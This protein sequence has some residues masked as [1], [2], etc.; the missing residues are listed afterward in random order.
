MVCNARKTNKQTTGE[1]G[2]IG[3]IQNDTNEEEK[4]EKKKRIRDPG[5][6]LAITE[7]VSNCA[8][9]NFLVWIETYQD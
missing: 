8:K 3:R 4:E 1:K 9:T 6:H 2:G 5:D 7:Q